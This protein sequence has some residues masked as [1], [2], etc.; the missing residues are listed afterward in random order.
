MDAETFRG[1]TTALR[2]H[3]PT[4]AGAVGGLVAGALGAF[5]R[6]RRSSVPV[7]ARLVA[8]GAAGGALG[9]LAQRW[10]WPDERLREE[11]FDAELGLED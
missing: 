2:R 9:R 5:G 8:A 7:T 3:P 10:T 4:V 1:V 6:S 11:L